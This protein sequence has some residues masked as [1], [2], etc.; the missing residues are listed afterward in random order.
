M[1]CSASVSPN[2]IMQCNKYSI[3][4]IYDMITHLLILWSGIAAV[5]VVVAIVNVD[6]GGLLRIGVGLLLASSSRWMRR[7]SI[8]SS[9]IF[10][11]CSNLALASANF[12]SSRRLCSSRSCLSS[13]ALRF[14]A[15]ASSLLA[16]A[17]S[18]SFCASNW[19]SIVA[20]APEHNLLS[21][22]TASLLFGFA[23]VMRLSRP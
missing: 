5:V 11:V 9:A 3:Q 4:G 22:S 23:S 15:S 8:C 21:N 18:D 10:F 19:P 1:S 7:I 20:T 2:R 12:S 16:S 17:T 14:T 6:S 13:S